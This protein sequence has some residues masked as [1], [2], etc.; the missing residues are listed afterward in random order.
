[1]TNKKYTVTEKNGGRVPLPP[2]IGKDE[3]GNDIYDERVLKV[4][5][6]CGQ[7]E[8][9]REQKS[10]EWQVRLNEELKNWNYKYMVTLTFDNKSLKELLFKKKIKECNAACGYAIRHCLEYWRKDHKK[11]LKHWFISEMGHEG[12]ERIHM[13]GIIFSNEPLEYKIEEVK[14]N[15]FLA[16]WK[17]WK[18]GLIHIGT[19]CN[20]RTINYIVKYVTKIDNDHKG[21]IG[22]IFTSPGMGKN[23]LDNLY[24]NIYKYRKNASIDYYRLNNGSKVKLPTYYKNKLYNENERELIWR[25]YMDTGDTTIKGVIYKKNITN[26][27]L[28]NITTKAKEINSKNGYGSDSKEWRKREYNITARMILHQKAEYIREKMLKMTEKCKKE[29]EKF[30]QLMK[31]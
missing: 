2:V 11:S 25:D 16:R 13:H 22:Q 26:H 20:E 24:T 31:N 14:N 21:F 19:Y 18:Y 3:K 27:E 6:P 8:E 28:E 1:M 7:C 9:C 15:G 10:R 29:E 4:E 17:Y 23:F 5:I 12:T 30:A